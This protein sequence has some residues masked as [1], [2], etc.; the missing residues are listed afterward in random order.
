[1]LANRNCVSRSPSQSSSPETKKSTVNAAVRVALIFWPALK[2]PCGARLPRQPAEV[3]AVEGVELACGAEQAAPGTEQHDQREHRH[4]ADPRP[5]VDVLDQ[6]PPADRDLEARQVEHQ[7]GHEQD[8]EAER[9]R[10]VQRAL[11]AREA[12]DVAG[13]HVAV[14]VRAADP[15]VAVV[16]ELL[17]VAVLRPRGRALIALSHLTFL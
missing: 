10:P 9:V 17:P 7:P 15:G 2:R 8:E 16:A 12:A 4:P 5:E 13:A 6:R 14:P 1:M 11:G 3:V